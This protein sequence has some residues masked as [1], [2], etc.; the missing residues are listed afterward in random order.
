MFGRGLSW[1]WRG[2]EQL[3]WPPPALKVVTPAVSPGITQC[4]G[5]MASGG[6]PQLCLANGLVFRRGELIHGQSHTV[7]GQSQAGAQGLTHSP[8]LP[9]VQP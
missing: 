4:V 9:L 2:V 5:K 3:P 6:E 8:G 1:A 7:R